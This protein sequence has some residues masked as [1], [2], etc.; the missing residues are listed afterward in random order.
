M[1]K[2]PFAGNVIK[3]EK[4]IVPS[5]LH[6]RAHLPDLPVE[7]NDFVLQSL[8]SLGAT[9]TPL[10]HLGLVVVDVHEGNFSLFFENF[11]KLN[12]LNLSN[13]LRVLDYDLAIL[14]VVLLVL[15]EQSLGFPLHLLKSRLQRVLHK[16]ICCLHA[17]YAFKQFKALGSLAL[18]F[19]EATLEDVKVPEES[20]LERLDGLDV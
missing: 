19:L 16:F 8:P 17:F 6:F 7:E 9:V 2:K 12:L 10:V 5:F 15:L 14:L 13:A 1:I 18:V 4:V 20:L 11:M 3:F